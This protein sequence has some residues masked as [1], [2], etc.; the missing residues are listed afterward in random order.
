VKSGLSKATATRTPD[1]GLVCQRQQFRI[2]TGLVYLN[3]AYIGPLSRAAVEAGCSGV[4]R[5]AEPWSI[6]WPDFHTDVERARA[7]F[8]SLIGATADDIAVIPAVSYGVQLAALNLPIVKGQRIVAIGDAFPSDFYAWREL[9]RERGAELQVVPC[10]TN[11]EWTDALIESI[12]ERTAIVTVPQCHWSNGL[13]FDLERIG[14]ACRLVGAALVVDVSQSLGA[15]P[16]D[17]SVV[18]P[19][20]LICASYKWLLGP[21]SLAF[22][23]AAPHRQAGQ[24]LEYHQWSR[25]NALTP[26]EW[27]EGAIPYPDEFLPGARRY[28]MGERANFALIPIA[29]AAMNELLAWSPK[30]ISKYLAQLVERCAEQA[31][32]LGVA[33]LPPRHVRSSH[34]IGFR[35]PSG[36]DIQALAT[37]LVQERIRLSV[38]GGNLRISPHIY[39]DLEDIEQLMHIMRREFLQ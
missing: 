15:V 2:P 6:A 10:P 38:R 35:P 29:I 12:N 39:N 30:A 4:M 17:V 23:Y 36:T 16:F 3:A 34:M 25:I 7:T 18:R 9:A 13:R 32:A 14:A 27:P 26:P 1:I 37:R 5:K 8:A 24:P 31:L 21:Y 20:I 22:L 28:D 19:D 11:W 33:R